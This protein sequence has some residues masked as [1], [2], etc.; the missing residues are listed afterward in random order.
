MTRIRYIEL[1]RQTVRHENSIQL[2]SAWRKELVE[3]IRQDPVAS[4]RCNAAALL[5]SR[6]LLPRFA[7]H[8]QRFAI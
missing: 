3:V 2:A 6:R 5:A 8:R 4:M 7:F 1:R